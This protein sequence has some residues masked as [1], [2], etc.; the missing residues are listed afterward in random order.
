MEEKYCLTK[1]VGLSLGELWY[2]NPKLNR[3]GAGG[4]TPLA[5]I[6]WK[7]KNMPRIDMKS[8]LLMVIVIRIVWM[9]TKAR[10]LFSPFEV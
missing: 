9:K 5:I 10:T 1:Q 3:G 2:I 8:L 6:K 4:F 7:M